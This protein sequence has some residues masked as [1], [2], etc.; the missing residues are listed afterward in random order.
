MIA[1][2]TPRGPR[3]RLSRLQWIR[4][5]LV[6]A[7]VLF[8]VARVA[9]DCVRV[10]LPLG[11]FGYVTDGNG[12]VVQPPR[13]PLAN[14]DRILPGDR[15][16][17]DRIKPFDRKPGFVGLGYTYDNKVRYLPIERGGHER[18]LHLVARDEGAS[19]RV[20]TV[21]RI[22]IFIVVVSL[23]ALLFIIKPTVGTA[24]I[25]AYTLGGQFPTTYVDLVI[26][27]P[28]RAIPEWIASTLVGAARPALLL[29][30]LTLWSRRAHVRRPLVAVGVAVALALGT[31]HAYEF[32]RLVYAGVP[33]QR[34][35]DL[36]A[37]LSTAITLVT[38]IAFVAAFAR[39]RG[40]ARQRIGW[41][42]GA[43]ALAGIAS[44]T[45]DAL[46]PAR[47][48]GWVNG[49]LLTVA[50]LPILVV[51]IGVVRDRVFHVNFV[52]SRAL[53]YVSITAGVIGAISIVEEVGTLIWAYNTDLSYSVV[54]AISLVIGAFT[55]RLR[56]PIEGF[57]DKFI[58]RDRHTQ[59]QTLERIA[60]DILDASSDE[61]VHHT[62]L[63]TTSSA[64]GLAFA[65]IFSR[66]SDG[67]FVLAHDERWPSDLTVRVDADDPLLA[68]IAS[69]R[70]PLHLD[71]RK[72]A[73]HGRVLADDRVA[74]AAPIFVE[75]MLGEIV[76]YGRNPSGLDLDPNE[77][78][79]LALV[80]AHAS[81]A[82]GAIEVTRLRAAL[83]DREPRPLTT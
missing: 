75:R 78:E 79:G 6:G 63:T 10:F 66:A 43:F 20:I 83:V 58:F 35:D 54:I 39:A 3:V 24:A 82:L 44:L 68:S 31:L 81:I 74:F 16:R 38:T 55:S 56:A 61:A 9:P 34:L 40:R 18:I 36:Y 8:V 12:V 23:G 11:V 28:W 29:F 60:N 33:A 2:A 22:A 69:T 15:V 57:V 76:V 27:N 62:L 70:S 50:V 67:S 17:I 25:F 19:N 48:P 73:H 77:R 7:F 59:R 21:L 41:L 26:P 47:I 14:S 53:V 13:H 4:L 46:Y 72:A 51:W 71:G 5:A 45:S 30:A 32:Y 64:L 52:V 80:V 65:G 42:A 1:P 49:F 37:H